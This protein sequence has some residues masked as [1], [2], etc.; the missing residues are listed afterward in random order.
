MS[1]CIEAGKP[2]KDSR[3]AK[4][5]DLIDTFRIAAEESVRI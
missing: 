2:I 5:R 3:E 1:L 4:Y